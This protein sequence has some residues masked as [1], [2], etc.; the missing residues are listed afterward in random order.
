MNKAAPQPRDIET[1]LQDRQI[2]RDNPEPLHRTKI[3]SI[4]VAVVL[5]LSAVFAFTAASNPGGKDYIAYWTSAQLLLHH[6]DPYSP[7]LVFSLEREQGH[8]APTPLVMRNPPWALFLVA[9][10][11]LCNARVGLFLWT[12]V[13]IACIVV[14]IRLLKSIPRDG[15]FAFLF[16]PV[17][18]CVYSGQSSP[19]LL[20]GF[21]L[22]LRFHRT[23]PFLAGCALFLMAIKPHLF[24]VFWAI[25]L[26]DCIYLRTYRLVV[27]TAL[28]L[29]AASVLATLI[30]PHVWSQY[31]AML[32][33]SSL[34]TEF[35]PTLSMQ[36]RL[37]IAPHMGSLLF[38]PTA[39]A[40][41]WG[42]WYYTK[43][44]HSWD[45]SRHGMLVMLVTVAASPYGW[46]TDEAVL[47]PSIAFALVHSRMRRISFSI[48][49]GLNTIAL[50]LVIG[51]HASLSS[52]A[53]IWTPLAWLLWFI[54]VTSWPQ[55]HRNDIS[56][57][58]T[59]KADA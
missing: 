56:R 29:A 48:L 4:I 26:I 5:V 36:L 25:L 42:L 27:G 24:L 41:F 44:R 39:I 55:L 11:G 19:F 21:A 9:P 46:F 51:R 17:M 13:G 49:L 23:R 18:A 8:L 54:C 3:L 45:W 2:V 6:A 28:S 52:A 58:L 14:S 43:N 35:F 38:L 22:F 31:L 15:P 37:R 10:L 59:I 20:L 34:D 53:Y 47:L 57:E 12:L 7:S 40:I 16:A 33:A 32:R 1:P 50:Y 30:D